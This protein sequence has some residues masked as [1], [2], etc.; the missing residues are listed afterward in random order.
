MRKGFLAIAMAIAALPIALWAGT[1][2]IVPTTTLQAETSNNTSAANSFKSQN[3]GNIGA[4]NVSKVDIHSLLY[5]GAANTKVITHLMPWGGDP[6]HIDVGYSSHDPVQIHRQITDMISRGIDG[7]I[8]DWY[9]DKDYTDQTAKLVM[10]EAEQHPGFTFA[11]MIDKGAIALSPCSGCSPQ[12]TLIHQVQY[13]EQT[14]IP[15][16]AY[17]RVNNR[18]VIT[19]FDIDLHYTIDWNAVSKA[20]STNPDFIFQHSSGFAHAVSGGS[21]AW[22]IVNVT[23]YGM[24]YLTKFYQ[25]GIAAPQEYTIGGAYKGF[26]DTLASWGSNRITGQQ[27]GQ[28]WLQTF[29]KIN[30]F[31]NSGKQLDAVQLVT[32]NDYEEGTEIESGIDNCVSITANL[33]GTVVR[34]SITGNENTIDHYVVYVSTDGKNLMP[35]DTLQPGA[36][37]LDLASYQLPTGKY[38]AYVQ[39]VGVPTMIN[40][41]SLAVRYTAIGTGGT[42]STSPQFALGV[43]PVSLSVAPGKSGSASLTVT[44]TAG[45]MQTPVK[46]SCANLPAGA[47]CSFLPVAVT[48]G[49]APATSVVTI[50]TGSIATAFGQELPGKRSNPGQSVLFSG[51]GVMA[52]TFSGTWSRRKILKRF[53]GIALL[54]VMAALLTFCGGAGGTT[55]VTP[56][57]SY[58]VTIQ[59]DSGAQ[60]S[61]T[62]VMLTVQ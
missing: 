37:T 49:N 29:A 17:M 56:P 62:V 45:P 18:P 30:N 43:S 11:I 51:L 21:Y 14:Y 7:V 28:T 9:G 23:D 42:T 57:G 54:G 25:A 10:A 55:A 8:I 38:S 36:R 19:N 6:R 46:L 5:V 61:S 1:L 58:A 3:N 26:N 50:S 24:S 52:I 39:V 20:A 15:S 33:S 13:V 32:W 53:F 31:Y 59:G 12:Q 40:H 27:C 4:G 16:S 2:K 47:V 48:P 34:W 22:V 41:M 44:P 60:S 35:L